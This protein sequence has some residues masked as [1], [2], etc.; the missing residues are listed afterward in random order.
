MN[1]RHLSMSIAAMAALSPALTQAAPASARA[2]AAAFADTLASHG[3]GGPKF[4]FD[5]SG[6]YASGGLA[7]FYPDE[8]RF[9]LQALDAKSGAPLLHATCSTDLHGKVTVV[10]DRALAGKL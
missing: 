8:R 7:S 3:I 4:K 2:C 5:Y 6:A 9:E 10:T 1:I